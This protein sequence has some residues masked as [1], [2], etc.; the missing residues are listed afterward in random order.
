M[1]GQAGASPASALGEARHAGP[2][3]RGRET[4]Q[5]RRVDLDLA[6]VI[7]LVA[8]VAGHVWPVGPF[9]DSVFAWHVPLFFI[10]TG[11]FWTGGRGLREEVRRRARA[12]LL[13]YAAWLVLISAVFV[14]LVPKLEHH[15]IEW[16][17]IGAAVRGGAVAGR[18]FTAFWFVTVLFFAAVARRAAERAPEWLGWLA[19]IAGVAATYWIGGPLAETPLGIGLAVPCA[20]FVFVGGRMR[21]HLDA[22]RRPGIAGL[23]LVLIPE[24]AV[25]LRT[26]HPVNLKHGDFGTPVLGVLVA[27][28]MSAGILLLARSLV[29]VLPSGGHRIVRSL[30]ACG[31]AV[32]LTHAVVL[33]EMNT[34]D[35]GGVLDLVFALLG[36]WAVA[37]ALHRTALSALLLGVP[38][39]NHHDVSTGRSAATG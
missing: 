10:L 14:V 7:G 16:A 30:A 2:G 23:G 13:P 31:I 5:G 12:L 6:R 36:P 35:S 21:P 24:A 4:G 26:V 1:S 3:S 11:W 25:L 15:H 27:V 22:V 34:P 29:R 17:W 19:A 32:V 38:R 9:A 33:L 28:S 37:L 20:L 8:V 18:P 39:A